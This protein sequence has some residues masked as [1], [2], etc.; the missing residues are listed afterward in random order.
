MAT[1][2]YKAI[3]KGIWS[4]LGGH[5]GF[6]RAESEGPLSMKSREDLTSCMLPWSNLALGRFCSYLK[7]DSVKP[8]LSKV[9]PQWSSGG[10]G[11]QISSLKMEYGAFCVTHSVVS[12]SLLSHGLQPTRLFCSSILR[13]RILE[14]V[15]LPFSMGSFLH[16]IEPGSPVLQTNSLSSEPPGKPPMSLLFFPK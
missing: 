3:L 13:T 2:H 10:S 12:D 15:A 11:D 7:G 4:E 8:F 1:Q 9:K 6:G 16:R 5:G 14:W